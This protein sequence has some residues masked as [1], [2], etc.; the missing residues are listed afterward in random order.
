MIESKGVAGSYEGV[1]FV[2][3]SFAILQ[4]LIMILK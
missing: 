2:L 1:L 3:D 4:I